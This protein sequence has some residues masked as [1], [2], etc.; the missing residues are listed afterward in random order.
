MTHSILTVQGQ[1]TTI[2][3]DTISNL[4]LL[5]TNPGITSFTQYLANNNTVKQDPMLTSHTQYPHLTQLQQRKLYL[6]ECCAHESFNNINKWIHDG[7]FPHIDK[8]LAS[9]PDPMCI[10][11]NFGK[12]AVN[13]TIATLAIFQQATDTQGMA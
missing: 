6:H 7:R 11:Y 1:Q 2:S 4:P 9:V 5:Y 13:L 12:A 3:Y 8:S 10:T